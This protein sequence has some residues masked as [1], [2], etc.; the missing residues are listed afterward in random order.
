MTAIFPDS[1]EAVEG[2]EALTSAGTWAHHGTMSTPARQKV[3]EVRSV[4]V[5]RDANELLRQGWDLF[6]VVSN[7]EHQIDKRNKPYDFIL[8]KRG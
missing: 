7:P 5:E 2:S 6:A 1:L 3:I 8:V 4:N